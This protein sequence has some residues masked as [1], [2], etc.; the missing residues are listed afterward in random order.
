MNE[1]GI[2]LR[3]FVRKAFETQIWLVK[4]I[5]CETFFIKSFAGESKHLQQFTQRDEKTGQNVKILE[6]AS[7]NVS[8][9]LIESE[10]VTKSREGG[11]P[12][13]KLTRASLF[14]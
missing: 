9:F 5:D 10:I 14:W 2:K 4:L 12:S 13:R 1:A 7:E 6:L 3:E 11:R 8:N